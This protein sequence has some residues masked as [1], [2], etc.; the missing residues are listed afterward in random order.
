M[1]ICGDFDVKEWFGFVYLIEFD[2]GLKYIGSKQLWNKITST[3]QLTKKYGKESNWKSYNSSSKSVKTLI[4]EGFTYT[5]TIVSLWKS[6]KE[7]MESELEMQK[8]HD[9][10]VSPFYLNKCYAVLTNSDY[11]IT[12]RETLR[13][14]SK[15]KWADQ[16]YRNLN[17]NSC[18]ISRWKRTGVYPYPYVPTRSEVIKL[19]NDQEN[20]DEQTDSN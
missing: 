10:I 6:K 8:E 20:K 19:L 18:K 11:D 4:S 12:R 13:D 3:K 9:A 2:N 14:I 5:K 15:N 16:N 7:L 1:W 17:I